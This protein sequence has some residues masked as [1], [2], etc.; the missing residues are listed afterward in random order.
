MDEATK[1][2]YQLDKEYSKVFQIPLVENY[3]NSTQKFNL[4]MQNVY[5]SIEEEL[6]K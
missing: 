1:K 3:F 2:I 6:L 5:K 4:L